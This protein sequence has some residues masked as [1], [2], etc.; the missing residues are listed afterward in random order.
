MPCLIDCIAQDASTLA[1]TIAAIDAAG[2]DARDDASLTHAALCLRRLGNDPDFLGN[3]ILDQLRERHREVADDSAYGAQSIMLSHGTK[4]Y[5][6]RANIWPSQQDYAFRASGGNSFVY[7]T[8]HDHNFDFLTLGY[9]GPGYSSDCYEYDYEA[10]SGWQG[11]PAGL[12]F[13]ER[14]R[15][16][17]GTLMLYRAHVDVHSQLPPESMSV[18]LN[19]MG[20]DAAQG[21]HDQYRFDPTSDTIASII[22]PTSTETFLRL[23]VGLG[24]SEAHDLAEHFGHSHPSDRIRLASFHA[25][26]LLA[27]SAGRDALWREAELSGSR[28]VAMEAKARR[29]QIA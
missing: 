17:P 24:G 26:A 10:V 23:A 2:F 16:S 1:D 22:N 27:D 12:R 25:R 11:E 6:L 7:G 13:V 29:H 4:G 18:S 8:P 19:V 15:L 9:F 3:L 28:M 5:F 14:S 21:W 20:V